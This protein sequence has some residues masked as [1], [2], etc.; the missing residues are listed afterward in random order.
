MRIS[1]NRRVVLGPKAGFFSTLVWI[2]FTA[3]L[4]LAV[5]FFARRLVRACGKEI[6]I[7]V[8]LGIV[9]VAAALSYATRTFLGIIVEMTDRELRLYLYGSA[10]PPI[11]LPLESIIAVEPW[12]Q[13]EPRPDG[14]GL[15]R[16]PRLH[17]QFVGG[18]GQLFGPWQ[19]RDAAADYQR[20][21]GLLG[22]LFRGEVELRRS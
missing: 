22:P 8:G 10:W 7:A 16:S 2:C 15:E 17:V 18:Q 5:L 12:R 19:T 3:A 1:S 20:L 14:Y 9:P 4:S 13:D 11:C 6:G 21:R